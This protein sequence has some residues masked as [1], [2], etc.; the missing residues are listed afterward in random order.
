VDIRLW[1]LLSLATGFV[2]ALVWCKQRARRRVVTMEHIR[3]E[4]HGACIVEDRVIDG[5]W[6]AAISMTNNSRRPRVAPVFAERATVTAGRRAYL[7]SVYLDADVS[8][9]NPGDVALARVE[10]VLPAATCLRRVELLV[11]PPEGDARRLRLAATQ[12][13]SGPRVRRGIAV[14]LLR[15]TGPSVTGVRAGPAGIARRAAR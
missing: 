9:V 5:I 7:A 14:G 15:M 11:L 13:S 3:V 6:R 2:A 10:F 12:P 4:L 8:E 1:I